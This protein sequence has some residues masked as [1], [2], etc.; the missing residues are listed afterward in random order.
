MVWSYNTRRGGRREAP[1][2]WRM[3]VKVAVLTKEVRST[4]ALWTKIDGDGSAVAT[5]AGQADSST[6]GSYPGF[7]LVG[8]SGRAWGNRRGRLGGFFAPKQRRKGREQ[9]SGAA[10]AHHIEKKRR[11]EGGSG[12]CGA[13]AW[14]ESVGRQDA[15]A[16]VAVERR[17]RV[18]ERW[19]VWL[20]E[21]GMWTDCLDPTL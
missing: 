5:G 20:D 6:W 9:G 3:R 4:V 15:G 12:A 11:R 19:G 13:Q 16:T 1:L 8:Q 21:N 2:N 18:G 14:G 7:L 10:W 17:D